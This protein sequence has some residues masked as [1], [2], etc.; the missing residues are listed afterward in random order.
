MANKFSFFEK[1]RGDAITKEQV[2]NFFVERLKKRG[3]VSKTTTKD[4]QAII[5]GSPSMGAYGY[6]LKVDLTSSKDGIPMEITGK[7]TMRLMGILAGLVALGALVL[8]MAKPDEFIL[9]LILVP[10][11]L[12][13]LKTEQKRVVKLVEAAVNDLKK[14]F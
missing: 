5:K 14:E 12:L 4:D 9:G 13:S 1:F 11:V 7:I 8:G 3:K 6:M 2:F 10:L